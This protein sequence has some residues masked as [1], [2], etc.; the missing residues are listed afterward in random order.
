MEHSDQDHAEPTTPPEVQGAEADSLSEEATVA[1]PDLP[2]IGMPPMAPPPV[3]KRVASSAE[4]WSGRQNF[5]D[6]FIDDAPLLSPGRGSVEEKI[7]YLRERL[8]RAESHMH[9]LHEA[10]QI[11]EE[12]IDLLEKLLTQER[13]TVEEKL[14]VI[15]EFSQRFVHIEEFLEQKRQEMESYAREVKQSFAQRDIDEQELRVQLDEAMRQGGSLAASK[16]SIIDEQRQAQAL[17]NEKID[18]LQ[19]TIKHMEKEL[20]RLKESSQGQVAELQQRVKIVEQKGAAELALQ[21][22]MFENRL[23]Q[24]RVEVEDGTKSLEQAEVEREEQLR[25]REETIT[26]L[27]DTVGQHQGQIRRLEDELQISR[28]RISTV[29]NAN[30]QE[31]ERTTEL[32][33]RTRNALKHAHSI[34][35]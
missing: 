26:H 11:R 23:N 32:L 2:N 12:E 15:K 27:H 28:E 21:R 5:S 1:I 10:W 16:Q 29:Q 33:A 8:K 35:Q 17:K 4:R 6:L 34:L 30:N 31:K 25:L 24:A 7:Q 14:V 3:P 20:E 13:G 19:A 22:E 9:K 18:S